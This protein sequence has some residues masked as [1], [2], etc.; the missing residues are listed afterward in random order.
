MVPLPT[1]VRDT[2]LIA[3]IQADVTVHFGSRVRQEWKRNG[4]IGEGASGIVYA[5]LCVTEVASGQPTRRAV[6]QIRDISHK[7]YIRELE[8]LAVFSRHRVSAA[9]CTV[10]LTFDTNRHA[11]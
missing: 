11:V 9:L 6:K 2:Q 3:E 7:D 4:K 8:A 10:V 1:Q 5:E